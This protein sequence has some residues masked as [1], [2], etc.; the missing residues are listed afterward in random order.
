[1]MYLQNLPWSNVGTISSWNINTQ[2]TESRVGILAKMIRFPLDL[3]KEGHGSCVEMMLPKFIMRL[4]YTFW[5][6]IFILNILLN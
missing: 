6:N 3:Q 4:V 1:M 2:S 5:G